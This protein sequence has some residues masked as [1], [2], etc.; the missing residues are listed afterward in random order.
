MSANVL[1]LHSGSDRD[2]GTLLHVF[3][4]DLKADW[5]EIMLV[6]PQLEKVALSSPRSSPI[7]LYKAADGTEHSRISDSCRL[8]KEGSKPAGNRDASRRPLNPETFGG[9]TGWLSI[10]CPS[11]GYAV[12]QPNFRGIEMDYGQKWFETNGFQ[13][14]GKSPLA[15]FQSRDQ[16][17]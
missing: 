11:L 10:F 9:L 17:G 4:R 7:S 14:L 3:D 8:D 1:L 5:S 13:K 12:L 15:I 2:P 6:R 16:T